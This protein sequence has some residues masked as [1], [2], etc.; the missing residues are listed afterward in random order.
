MKI[1][2]VRAEYEARKAAGLDPALGLERKHYASGQW[3]PWNWPGEAPDD[4]WGDGDLRYNRRIAPPIPDEK[5]ENVRAEFDARKAAGLDPFKGLEIV[6]SGVGGWWSASGSKLDP[7]WDQW[8]DGTIRYNRKVTPPFPDEAWD[9]RILGADER[10]VEGATEFQEPEEWTSPALLR[11]FAD[12]VE[13]VGEGWWREW[14]VLPPVSLTWGIALT[15]VDL[16]ISAMQEPSRVRRRPRTVNIEVEIPE[17]MREKPDRG[18]EREERVMG[19][20]S[21]EKLKAKLR[22]LRKEL[23]HVKFRQGRGLDSLELSGLRAVMEATE[24][25]CVRFLEEANS[26]S[27]NPD[28]RAE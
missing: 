10:F 28:G 21:N 16:V 22:R 26:T 8:P 17:P 4:S 5:T 2:D 15:D 13:R 1:E 6:P 7:E 18:A 23:E 11:A 25:L 9:A 20:N 27:E 19:A 24:E 14:N 3:R 12:D